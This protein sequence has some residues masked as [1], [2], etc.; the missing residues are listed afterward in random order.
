[1]SWLRAAVWEKA[2]A[3]AGVV[4]EVEWKVGQKAWESAE[5]AVSGRLDLQGHAGQ[6]L[7]S[8]FPRPSVVWYLV[9]EETRL[10]ALQR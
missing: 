6:V 5:K 1:M 3:V 8:F 2:G 10:N 4:E 7:A 9:F